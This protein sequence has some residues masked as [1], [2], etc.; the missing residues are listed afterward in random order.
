MLALFYA[1]LGTM[2]AKL[3]NNANIHLNYDHIILLLIIK[4]IK[5]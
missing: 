1:S 5:I 2:Y 3:I 4:V